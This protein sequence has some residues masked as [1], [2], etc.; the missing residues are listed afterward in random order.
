MNRVTILIPMAW[1]DAIML[2]QR[3]AALLRSGELAPAELA[4]IKRV[5][6]EV[7]RAGAADWHHAEVPK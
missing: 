7:A 3:I 4:A 2:G 1:D 5:Y 6:D